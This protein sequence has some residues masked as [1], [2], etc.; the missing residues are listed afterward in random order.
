MMGRAG[1]FAG[2]AYMFIRMHADSL[3]LI[4]PYVIILNGTFCLCLIIISLLML[5]NQESHEEDWLCQLCFLLEIK[6]LS[7]VIFMSDF[8]QDT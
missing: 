6:L 7:Y 5:Y 2:E 1:M 8:V 3:H 4:Y